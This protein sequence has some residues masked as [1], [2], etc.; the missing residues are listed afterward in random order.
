MSIFSEVGRVGYEGSGGGDL[1]YRVYDKDRVVLGRAMGD[2]LRLAVCYWHSFNWPGNDI[3]G[4]GTL[5]RPWLGGG[6]TQE[7]AEKKL[8]AA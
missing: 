4:S 3:F 6:V 2:W 8:E 5:S 7:V 1:S